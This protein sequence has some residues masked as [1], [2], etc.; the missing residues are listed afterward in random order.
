MSQASFHT[1]AQFEKAVE[2]LVS[3]ADAQNRGGDL[4]RLVEHLKKSPTG[5]SRLASLVMLV[6]EDFRGP[7][8]AEVD[9]YRRFASQKGREVGD[10]EIVDAM[11]VV[12]ERVRGAR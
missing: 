7:L 3:D 8:K 4:D 10:D 12:Y 2:R 11:L 9:A 1:F 5:V 6:D